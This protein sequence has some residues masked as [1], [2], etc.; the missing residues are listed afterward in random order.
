[1][2]AVF[3]EVRRSLPWI[4]LVTRHVVMICTNVCTRKRG[5]LTRRRSWRG[6]AS[7][8]RPSRLE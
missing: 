6:P 7:A 5:G 1:V 4:P 8:R 3:G 2:H